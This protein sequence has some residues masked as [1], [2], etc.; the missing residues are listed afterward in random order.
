VLLAERAGTLAAL[1]FADD[2]GTGG[3]SVVVLTSRAD[4]EEG[5]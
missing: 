2:A 3:A 1:V 4:M 5:T